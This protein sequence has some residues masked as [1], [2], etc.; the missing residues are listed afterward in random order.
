M[1]IERYYQMR[2]RARSAAASPPAIPT[3]YIAVPPA[4]AMSNVVVSIGEPANKPTV[5]DIRGPD[6]KVRSFPVA[7]GNDVIRPRT[8]VLH[9]GD[10]LTIRFAA[11]RPQ[12]PK[13]P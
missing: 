11:A 7:S 4:P 6:G 8:I 5:V 2:Q 12:A 9:P 10:S 1:Q 13:K 3:R